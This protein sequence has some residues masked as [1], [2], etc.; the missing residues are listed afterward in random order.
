MAPVSSDPLT[1]SLPSGDEYSAFRSW[2]AGGVIDSFEWKRAFQTTPGFRDENR[3]VKLPE[4]PGLVATD[5]LEPAG[6]G[7][8]VAYRPMCL[9][10]TGRRLTATGPVVS[11][12]VQASYCAFHWFPL[13]DVPVAEAD[14]TPMVALTRPG[15]SGLVEVVGHTAAV[16]A[17]MTRGTPN[18]VVHFGT[19]DS[20]GQLHDVTE[21]IRKSGRVET[22]AAVV[23][24]LNPDDLSRARYID[25]VIYAEAD[26]RWAKT[27]AVSIDQRPVTVLIDAS[28]K[29]A[30]QH[31]GDL[32]PDRLGEMLR[33]MLRPGRFTGASV[34]TTGPG[35]GHPP[36]NFLF[37]YGPGQ[38]LT[39]RKLIGRP[40]IL[41][42]SRQ[43]GRTSANAAQEPV[44]HRH[45]GW[46]QAL[47]LRIEDGAAPDR[48]VQQAAGVSNT[49]T[50]VPDPMRAIAKAYGISAWPTTVYIDAQ[51]VVRDVRHAHFETVISAPPATGAAAGRG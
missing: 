44:S 4:A 19:A 35:L 38:E 20:A 37:S 34:V 12:P 14:S 50:V 15:P 31:G 33:K 45:R 6:A 40:V 41:M 9:T 22:P 23:A 21:A 17:D 29:L 10:I 46:E 18:L 36:P 39:L 49:T 7:P 1:G 26:D 32:E 24:V 48:P 51:G 30:W 25:G 27:W 47:V 16:R 11:Q 42:F 3:F 13:L 43:N 2:I 8:M 5:A 28:G